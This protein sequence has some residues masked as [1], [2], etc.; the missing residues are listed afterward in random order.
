M[1]IPKLMTETCIKECFLKCSN[2][3]KDPQ[4]IGFFLRTAGLFGSLEYENLK[5]HVQGLFVDVRQNSQWKEASVRVGWLEGIVK[6]V[7]N[8]NAFLWIIQQGI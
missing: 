4:T 5:P 6:L 1:T 3:C 7:Q 2:S 8:K